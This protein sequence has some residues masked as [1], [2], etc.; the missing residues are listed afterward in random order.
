MPKANEPS[1]SALSSRLAYWITPIRCIPS[2]RDKSFLNDLCFGL[3]T[4]RRGLKYALDVLRAVSCRNV[5]LRRQLEEIKI[6]KEQQE[7]FRSQLP[8]VADINFGGPCTENERNEIR[9]S[10]SQIDGV[11]PSLPK[12]SSKPCDTGI[13]ER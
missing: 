1:L 12:F 4:L 9:T 8:I 2:S 10:G 3:R 5:L 13:E 7:L 6:R 11:I